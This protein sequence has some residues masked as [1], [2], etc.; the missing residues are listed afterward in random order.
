MA[1][2]TEY[3][4]WANRQTWNVALWLG[5]D[6]GLYREANRYVAKFGQSITAMG[7]RAFVRRVMGER[8]P[9]GVGLSRV[10]WSQIAEMLREME[11]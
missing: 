11:A 7:A 4:G 2:A 10:R 5:N 3:N 8:T 1:T 9:D 6:E